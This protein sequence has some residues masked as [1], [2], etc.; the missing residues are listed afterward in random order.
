[1]AVEPVSRCL[2]TFLDRVATDG[3]SSDLQGA[4]PVRPNWGSETG[5]DQ[6]IIDENNPAGE[7]AE[8]LKAAVC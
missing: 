7:L 3:Y 1:M 2:N 6:A 8:R 5:T 4:S